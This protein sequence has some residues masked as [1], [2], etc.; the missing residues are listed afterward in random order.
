MT[1]SLMGRN[2]KL[3]LSE[4][5]HLDIS[6]WGH[7]DPTYNIQRKDISQVD[8]GH[9]LRDFVI[10]GGQDCVESSLTCY[11]PCYTQLEPINITEGIS[12]SFCRARY[13]RIHLNIIEILTICEVEVYGQQ[14]ISPSGSQ[15][16]TKYSTETSV[17]LESSTSAFSS[18]PESSFSEST[19]VISDTSPF[20]MSTS[21]DMTSSAYTTTMSPTEMTMNVTVETGT[22]EI[23]SCRCRKIEDDPD[24]IE[25]KLTEI[26]KN[27][28]ISIVKLSSSRRKKTSATDKRPSASSVGYVGVVIL[29]VVMGLLVIQDILSAL[30]FLFTHIKVALTR[31]ISIRPNANTAESNNVE[32]TLPRKRPIIL[33]KG[34]RI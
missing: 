32:L 15:M 7:F 23:C 8:W 21:I 28:T 26:K 29:S 18:Y 5:F 11:T 1:T 22:N 4:E 10:E 2:C 30:I 17:I 27:L 31:E 9:R 19:W 13:V 16:C 3:Q 34:E 20:E 14:V 24:V 33:N 25:E 12:C 6:W